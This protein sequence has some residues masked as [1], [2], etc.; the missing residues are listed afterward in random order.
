MRLRQQQARLEIGEPRRHH[1]IV[2]GE[3]EPH[4]PRLLDEGEI[5]IG[6]REDRDFREIDLLLACQHQQQIERAFEALDIDHQRRL[7]GGAI[8]G[9]VLGE[10]HVAGLHVA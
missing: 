4:A 2:G 9:G 8:D 6:E 10:W 3:L 7:V 1:E 5:L